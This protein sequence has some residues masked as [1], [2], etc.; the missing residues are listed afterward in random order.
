[1]GPHPL[2]IPIRLD[3]GAVTAAPEHRRMSLTQWRL[4]F[5]SW[6]MAQLARLCKTLL[7]RPDRWAHDTLCN[8]KP[9]RLQWT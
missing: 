1:M 7:N 2:A 4:G 8:G 3:P 5:G 6:N 9:V